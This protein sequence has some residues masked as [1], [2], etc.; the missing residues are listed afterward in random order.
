MSLPSPDELAAAFEQLSLV[1]G[2][3]SNNAADI[4]HARRA[5]YEAYLSEGFDPD[6]ALTL[7]QK[8]LLA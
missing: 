7:C 5:L 2:A 4:A 1:V 3:I 6:Q 8:L